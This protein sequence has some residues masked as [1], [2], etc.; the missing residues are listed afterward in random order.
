MCDEWRRWGTH[1]ELPGLIIQP[2]G[3]GGVA[4]IAVASGT[5]LQAGAVALPKGP[6]LRTPSG[7]LR[8]IPGP[9]RTGNESFRKMAPWR[10]PN[11][12]MSQIRMSKS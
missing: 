10:N 6:K 1:S 9:R 11:Q 12:R 4:L 5:A 8:R 7:K 3:L 2:A